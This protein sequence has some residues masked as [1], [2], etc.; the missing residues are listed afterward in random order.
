M[1]FS[2]HFNNDVSSKHL[3]VSGNGADWG[4][5]KLNESRPCGKAVVEGSWELCALATTPQ[6]HVSRIPK[7]H[8]ALA[9]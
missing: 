2:L 3:I 5:Q 6:H 9:V 4:A 8:C 1:A 7:S